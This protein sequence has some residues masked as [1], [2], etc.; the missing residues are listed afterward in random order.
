MATM[1]R[2]P[3]SSDAV[4]ELLKLSDD[5]AH[6]EV[7]IAPRRG[8]LVTSFV[9]AGRELLYLDQ[10]TLSD[11]Q[12]NV[13]GG[14]PV[15]F[16][17]PGKLE[18]DTW[19]REGR[20]GRLKQHGFARNLAWSVGEV[21]ADERGAD[22]TLA[23]D[24]NAATLAQ[25][26]WEFHAELTFSLHGAR[27][28]IRSRIENTSRARLPFALGY[29]PYFAVADKAR[30][31]IDAR[32]TRAFDNVK[33][34]MVEFEGFELTASEVD[35]LL[36]DHPGA[37]S[38]LHFPDGSRIQLRGSPDFTI[39]VVWTLAGKDFVCLE[40]WTAPG[41][42]LNSGERLLELEPGAAHESSLVLEFVRP[43]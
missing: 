32:A 10:A 5:R 30:V 7:V 39:W 37:E 17:S 19:H 4:G 3:S 14:I 42:A 22:V 13:R 16:P 1:T 26:P 23:L 11:P 15:L 18:A 31:S 33:K 36:L 29:H 6:S 24:S 41:G 20:T 40:P 21:H 2:I 9:V 38:A 28:G 34:Q 27:L 25:Y 35:L 43:G 12:K 8:A